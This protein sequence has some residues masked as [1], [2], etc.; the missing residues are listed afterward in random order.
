MKFLTPASL[1]LLIPIV[2]LGAA[3][4]VM[5]RRR[6]RFA[7]R[8]T[9]VD[10]LDSV[11]P[12]RPG[13]RRHLPVGV[14]GLSAAAMVLG[15][16]RPTAAMRVPTEEAI[17]MLAIDVSTSMQAVDVDPSRKAASIDKA[18]A[19]VDELPDDF[20]VGLA[21]FNGTAQ[22]LA[23]PTTDHAAVRV[24][25]T[26]LITGRG[27][28]GGDAIVASLSS[29][30]AALAEQAVAPLALVADD[31]SAALDDPPAATIVMLSDGATTKGVDIIEAA[32]MAVDANVP[33]S[34]ITFGTA[35]GTVTVNDQL[36]S[37]PPD[38]ATM[39]E[40]AEMTGGSAFEA[41]SAD[42]LDS[43]YQDIE[44]WVSTVVEERELTM[45]FVAAALG[46]LLL[47]AGAAFLWTG[48]FL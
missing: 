38:A 12:R 25:I 32:Q 13:W 33:I 30:E 36:A 9:N 5:Q 1:F 39:A 45:Y 14:A 18:A 20:H 3:Y 19:F 43:V 40:V 23:A 34:T 16:A 35:Q 27:T 42:E 29:I 41:A 8:F 21:A 44:S 4:M 37:V 11:L 10:L 26:N 6:N 7:V 48:R 31:E 22:V 15:L 24:A 17:V 47:A 2:V 46:L 28:A